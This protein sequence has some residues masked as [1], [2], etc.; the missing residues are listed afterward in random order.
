MIRKLLLTAAAALMMASLSTAAYADGVTLVAGGP[1]QTLTFASTQFP[2][3]SATATFQLQANGQLTVTLTNTS[4]APN[5][6]AKIGAFGFST[7]PNVS[8]SN[9]AYAGE[10]TGWQLSKNGQPLQ[11]T[12]AF[13]IVS[14]HNSNN[15]LATGDTGTATFTFSSTFTT[16]TIDSAVIHFQ[17]IGR[18]G[19]D[20]EKVPGTPETPIPEP[21]TMFLLGTGLAGVAAKVRKR[22]NAAKD[23]DTADRL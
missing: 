11:N 13:E 8:V 6:G 22:R 14:N 21:A 4:T 17:S 3:T 12:S 10:L 19:E 15:F 16:L 2:G 23:S 18:G 1:A 9:V 20:S 7:T 5:A